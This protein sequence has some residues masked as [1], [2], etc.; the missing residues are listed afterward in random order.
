MM[1]E[2]NK[3]DEKK[4][5][6]MKLRMTGVAPSTVPFNDKYP[7]IKI[8]VEKMNNACLTLTSRR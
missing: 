7:N 6:K 4:K 5:K 1:C 8:R 2:D 3:W